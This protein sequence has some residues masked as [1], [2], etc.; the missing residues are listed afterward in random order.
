MVNKGVPFTVEG[1][2]EYN[3]TPIKD[4]GVDVWRPIGTPMLVQVWI[5]Q[6]D[7]FVPVSDA[8]V[9]GRGGSFKVT[10]TLGDDVRAGQ[11]TLIIT[12]TI[13][14]NVDYLPCSWRDD[15]GFDLNMP[16]P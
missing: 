14:E 8:V 1:R 11:A 9:T 4:M 2:V 15:S 5:E 3:H 12:A 10:C 7:V 13:H 6:G 16:S